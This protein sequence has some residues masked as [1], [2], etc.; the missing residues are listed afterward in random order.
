MESEPNRPLD[1]RGPATTRRELIKGAGVVA[2]GLALSGLLAACGPGTTTTSAATDTPKRGGNFRIG[3]IGD[4]AKAIM[5][6]QNNIGGGDTARLMASFETLVAYNEKAKITTDLGLA[7][8][9]TQDKPDQWTIRL[10]Q[11]IEFHNGKTLSA[12]DLVYSL[13]RILRPDLALFGYSDLAPWLDPQNGIVKLDNRTVRL[14]LTQANP[15][16]AD[17]MAQYFNS[18]VPVGYEAYPAPQIGT[19]P[20]KLVSFTPGVETTFTRNNNYWR[21]GEPYF[22][23]VTI[24]EFNDPSS[25]VNALLAGQVDAISDLPTAQVAIV[26]AHSDLVVL[27]SDTGNWIPIE[28]AVDMPPFN[29][30]RVRQAFRLIADRPQLVEQAVSGHGVVAKDL[31]SPFDPCYAHD[32]PQRHQDLEQAKSLLKAA[33]QEGLVFDFHTTPN[34][35]AMVNEAYVFAQQAKG[36]GVT[37]NVHNDPNY[38]G[39]QYLHLALSVDCWFAHPYLL[40]VGEGDIPTAN[41]DATHWPPKNATGDRYLSLY[42]QALAEIDPS[43]RCQIIHEMQVIEYNEGGHIIAFFYNTIDAFS[44]KVSGLKSSIGNPP[45]LDSYGHGFR[46]IWFNS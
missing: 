9:L 8:S 34:I 7:E 45:T 36:A 6:G 16:I 33:G 32:L 26:K 23:Q 5:D 30:V 17:Q 37:L 38:Y 15:T 19:G 42:H 44:N 11:G 24:V 43:K 10:K 28:M 41:F 3:L 29:D 39:D 13:Q 14:Q 27:E 46:T 4:G 31:Y 40:Q 25:K 1:L 18:V 12:D 2:G 22:D 20:F 21:T 35:D